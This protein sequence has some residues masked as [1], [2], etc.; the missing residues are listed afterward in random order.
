MSE[1]PLSPMGELDDAELCDAG[2][3]DRTVVGR[4]V[5]ILDAVATGTPPVSLARLTIRTGLPKAT[6]RRIA[7][8]LARRGM[9]TATSMGYRIGPRLLWQGM[10]SRDR[11]RETITVQP[12]LQELYACSDAQIAWYAIRCH[13]EL[14]IAATAFGLADRAIVQATSRLDLSA[15]G[16]SLVLTAAGRLHIA[17]DDEL[18]DRIST[19]SCPPLTNH[20]VTDPKRLR[21]LLDAARA[22]GSALEY[23]Q[24][25]RGWSCAAEA[26]YDTSGDLIGV[27][28][29]LGRGF[30]VARRG[31]RPKIHRL[32]TELQ[33]ELT[34]LRP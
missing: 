13:G 9:L 24:V 23:E 33:T 6:V 29:V 11:Q 28:G 17:H 31:L 19:T 34:G 14:A 22:T 26:V 25:L 21:A 15:F 7:N 32:V 20:S 8:G 12:Y 3:G 27:L 30:S 2:A 4:A 16:P 1:L 5:R 18:I 10:R